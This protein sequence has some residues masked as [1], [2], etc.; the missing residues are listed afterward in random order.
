MLFSVL[1]H[2]LTNMPRIDYQ[3]S[4]QSTAANSILVIAQILC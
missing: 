3:C 2:R 1:A 4:N